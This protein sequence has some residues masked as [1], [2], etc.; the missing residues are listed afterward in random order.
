MRKL[1]P[2]IP[3]ILSSGYSVAQAMAGEHPELPQ[4]FLSK[5]YELAALSDTIVRFMRRQKV[6]S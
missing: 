5:P 1:V 4:A 2:G 3:V 6:S